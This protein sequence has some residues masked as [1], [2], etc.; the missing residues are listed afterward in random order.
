M[1]PIKVCFISLRSYPLFNHKSK[2]Y[3][4][5]AEVQISLL[6]REL[7]KDKHFIVSVITGNY[8]Q[9]AVMKKG[10]LKLFKT[11]LFDFFKILK[12]ANADAYIERTI[13]PKIILI[14]LFCRLFNKKFIY[15]VA[16][17]WDLN[18]KIINLADL[19]IA[20][21]QQQDE[22]L[23]RNSTIMP[24]IVQLSSMEKS[25]KR[26][27]ILWVGR[28]DDW[29]K[30][31][32]FIE[33]AK[34]YP[35][36]KFL[37][38][39]RSGQQK[40]PASNLPNLKIIPQV[41]YSKIINVFRQAKFLVNT[42]D[43]EGFPNT[44]L[45][46]GATGTPVLSFKVNPDHYLDKYHC[47]LVGQNLQKLLADPRKLKIMGKNHYDYVKKYHSLKNLK[48]FKQILYKL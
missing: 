26:K 32:A 24:S 30:P 2:A 4:G 43:A 34:N 17:D 27:Y 16:H 35:Q 20:Q 22:F 23:K 42:S 1:K 3:F 45:Q 28:A 10:R 40:T 14:Y 44:F 12:L 9:A 31:L 41:S 5:G 25:L 18:H 11:K 38:I 33:L 48:S 8:G 39:C 29:K 46:A 36:E 47:G 6:A 15:M 37:M 21:H 19:I 13:N 7:A